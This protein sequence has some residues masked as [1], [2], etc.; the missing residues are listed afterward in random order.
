MSILLVENLTIFSTSFFRSVKRTHDVLDVSIDFI[1]CDVFSPFRGEA[2]TSEDRRA[3]RQAP[4]RAAV[5][6][7]SKFVVFKLEKTAG[8]IQMIR[9]EGVAV[10]VKIF[11]KGVQ[12]PGTDMPFSPVYSIGAFYVPLLLNA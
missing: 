2:V 8:E 11:R 10:V 1:W 7:F 3:C 9:A 6:D 4:F 12:T 5:D